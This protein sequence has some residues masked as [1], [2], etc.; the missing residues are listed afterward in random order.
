MCTVQVDGVALKSCLM[1]APQ[2]EGACVRTVESLAVDNKLNGLQA[3]FTGTTLCNAV[4][5]H[6]DF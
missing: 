1:L 5:V 3:S 6:Q 2:L 4:F